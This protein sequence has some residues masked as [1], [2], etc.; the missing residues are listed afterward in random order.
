MDFAAFIQELD[1][2]RGSAARLAHLCTLPAREAS[3]AEL[4]HTL[5]PTVQGIVDRLGIERL[6]SHQAEAVDLALDGHNVV[7]VSGTA[8]GKTLCYTLPIAQRIYERPASRALLVYPTK[9]LAQDQLRRLADFGAGEAFIAATYDGDTP[10]NQRRKVKR[11]AQVVL[12]NPDML[13]VGILPYHHT[14][15][16]FFRSLTYVVLDEVHTYRGVFGSNTANIIR[17]LR[18]IAAHYGSRPQFICCSATIANPAE[19]CLALTGLEHKLVDHDGAPHGSKVFALWNPPVIEAKTGKRRSANLEASDLMAALARSHVRH[20]CFAVARTQAELMLTYAKKA[21]EGSGLEHKLMAYRGGY[22]P[23]ERREIERKLFEGELLGVTSTSALEVGVDIGGLDAVVM[24]GYPGSVA[25]TWQ[26][27]GRAGRGKQEALAVLVAMAGGIN[28]YLLEHPEYLLGSASE[29]AVIDPYNRFILGGHL[30]C[31]AYE[32]AIRDADSA[33][34]GEQMEEI[35]EVL[36]EHRYVTRRSAWYWIDPETYPA[37]CISIRSASGAGY[38][39]VCVHGPDG[40]RLLGTMDD[41]SAF[42]MI[43][44]GAVYL[45]GG[46]TYLVESLDLERRVAH[47]VRKDVDY[48]TVPM[49]AAEVRLGRADETR[50]LPVGGK[51][52]L[53]AVSVKS[54]VIG[55]ARRKQVTEQDLG[56]Y[57]LQLP[58]STYETMGLWFAVPPQDVDELV[59]NGHDLLGSLHALEHALIQLLPLFALCDAHDVGGASSPSH[60]DLGG[61]GLFLHDGYPGGVGI[62]EAAFDRIQELLAAVA[63]RIAACPCA[64]GCPSCVQTHDCGSFNRPLDKGGALL[65]ARRWL[66][67]EPEA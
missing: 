13:H 7:V 22:L 64:D 34:F 65:L 66:D 41:A 25:S 18:R 30:L 8:S 55:Y 57:D 4:A 58:P 35:L 24:A 54:A 62:C 15:A 56:Q 38:D 51:L 2:R 36:A 19:L 29:R 11:E 33:L 45:H 39:I 5:N 23:A 50:P 9:A 1:D 40:D 59:I 67:V 21:L 6:W 20:I 48:Y 46:E 52:S 37:A 16:D 53:G 3:F 42:R 10:R 47:V 32:L 63:D 17:R 61:P 14:W 44:Q 27:A 60:P 31:A 26:Q 43:H 12:T 49:V 28:Q